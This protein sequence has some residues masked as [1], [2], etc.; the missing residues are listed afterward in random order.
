MGH[1]LSMIAEAQ[2]QQQQ[3]GKSSCVSSCP[4]QSLNVGSMMRLDGNF[5][6][7]VK[8]LELLLVICVP[9]VFKF[10]DFSGNSGDGQQSDDEVK[11]FVTRLTERFPGIVVKCQK[12]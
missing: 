6:L 5:K 11:Q 12:Q 8:S 2:Q 7:L 4:L 3:R 9:G 10:L 1:F